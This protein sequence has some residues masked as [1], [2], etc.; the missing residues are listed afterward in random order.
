MRLSEFE[1]DVMGS[2]WKGQELTA[3]E[4]FK[5]LGVPR[6][7]TY[8]TIKA[9]IDRLEVKGAVV[10]TRT[11][12]RTIFYRAAIQREKIRKRLVKSFL[13]RLYGNDLRPLFAQLVGDESLGEEEL[14]YLR[15]LLEENKKSPR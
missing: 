9:I 12:G 2:F 14:S 5:L 7:V 4:V 11:E 3:P 13:R 10:R 8:S 1:L 6:G 15:Q